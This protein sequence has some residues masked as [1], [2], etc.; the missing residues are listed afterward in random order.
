MLLFGVAGYVLIEAVRRFVDPPDVASIPMLV[1]G[2]IGLFV[3]LI[4]FA[5]LRRARPRASTCAAPTSKWSQTCSA[6][7]A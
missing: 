4:A 7:S 3:N 6:L 2:V 1:V 5:L